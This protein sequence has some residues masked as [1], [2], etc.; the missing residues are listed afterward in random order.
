VRTRYFFSI[1]ISNEQK[2]DTVC[3]RPRTISLDRTSAFALLCA[4]MN[5]LTLIA[6][7]FAAAFLTT[8]GLARAQDE[9]STVGIAGMTLAWKAQ[10]PTI[11]F[12]VWRGLDLLATTEPGVN[13]AKLELPVDQLSTLTVT[14]HN[15]TQSSVHSQ[16]LVAMPVTPQWSQDLSSWT[17]Q[18]RHI[19][20]VEHKP[21]LFFRAAFPTQ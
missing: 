21:A 17:A 5:R 10:G 8:C 1:S 20:F 19:F 3:F 6:L 7:L 18:P 11:F 9:P 16:P 12:R 2:T 4:R 15:E 14:A 13:R